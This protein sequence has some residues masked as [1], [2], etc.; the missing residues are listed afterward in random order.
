MC[1]GNHLSHAVTRCQAAQVSE[2]TLGDNDHGVVLG[3][4]NVRSERN[5]SRNRTV[6]RQRRRDERG[7]EGVTGEVTGT[8]DAVH[9]AAA[10]DVGG[11]DVAVDV[12]LNHAVGGNQT[13]TADNLR[14]VGDLL[15]AQDDVFAVASSLVV[16]A[17]CRF[18]R[19]GERSS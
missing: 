1:N 3:V 4:V 13:N 9:H 18:R 8:T 15:R 7:N 6:L 11:V 17:L 2:S 19:Q 5:D 12:G 16:H 10:V 14:V